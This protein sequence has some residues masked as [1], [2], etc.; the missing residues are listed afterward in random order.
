MHSYLLVEKDPSKSSWVLMELVKP[1]KKRLRSPDLPPVMYR[2]FG[3]PPD[4]EMRMKPQYV[5]LCCKTCGRYDDDAAFDVGF[6]D[7]VTIRIQGDFGHTEDRILVV[8]DRFL[9]VLKKAKVRGY[10][11]RPA[12]TSGWHALRAT[13]HVDTAKGVMKP[14]K[15]I[16]RT[17]G[18]SNGAVGSFE[19]RK[20][21]SIP[22]QA[23]TFFTTK[24]NWHRRFY[25]RET[26]LTEDV[27][28][29]LKA[30]G[31][32]GGWC[33]RLWTDEEVRKAQE[34]AKAGIKWK[35]PSWC[36]P[37]SGKAAKPKAKAK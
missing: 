17:C 25:D 15:P 6:K 30:G 33:N 12:G 35:P 10:E 2:F 4:G 29:A 9:S 13:V 23:N 26:F 5:P 11:T 18:R 37:L 31:I 21:L 7:P 24:T 27:M 32:K 14:V 34:K 3:L 36:V 20:Q 1:V 28:E 16:C 22:P 19:H 8:S